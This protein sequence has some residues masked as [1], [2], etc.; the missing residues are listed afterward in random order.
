MTVAYTAAVFWYFHGFPDTRP[1]EV[2]AMDTAEEKA[3]SAAGLVSI[4]AMV[5]VRTP[6]SR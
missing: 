1:A 3:L 2:A 5:V 6:S 4:E